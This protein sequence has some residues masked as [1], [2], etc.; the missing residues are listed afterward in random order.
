MKFQDRALTC[1][2]CRHSFI[3]TAGEQEFFAA[4]GFEQ[5]PTR[6]PDCRDRRR[7]QKLVALRKAFE[8]ICAQ[9]GCQT[10]V[11][12]EPREGSNVFCRDCYRST[13]SPGPRMS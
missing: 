10:T 7:T 8:V 6:C 11:P 9:C 4:R 5:L 2:G 12:F 3:F 13:K 1:M